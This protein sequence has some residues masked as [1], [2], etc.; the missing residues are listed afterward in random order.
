MGSFLPAEQVQVLAHL[1][2]QRQVLSVFF[3]IGLLLFIVLS[4]K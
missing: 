2:P 1:L 3:S 4:S